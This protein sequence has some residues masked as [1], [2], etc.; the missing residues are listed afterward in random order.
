[1]KR[2]LGLL[3]VLP[4]VLAV[5]ACAPARLP[6]V[7]LKTHSASAAASATPSA[8]P[9][10]QSPVSPPTINST[11][12]LINGVPDPT[13]DTT[14]SAFGEWAFFTDAQKQVWCQFTIFSA[15]AP[16][17]YCFVVGSGKSA[18]T[19]T[20]P[21]GVT[22]GCDMSSSLAIDGYGLGLAVEGLPNG[23]ESGWAGC[24]NDFFAP[25]A[26]LAKTKVLPSGGT[27]A[28]SPFSCT[29]TASVAT[30]HYT[31]SYSGGSGTITLGLHVATFSQT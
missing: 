1:M 19:F 15:D 13:T 27:L 24:S 12:Y 31:D 25:A 7:S 5:A 28:V 8:T 4:L 21:A 10:A 22:N 29:V 17:S 14:G 3:L 18:K 11:D 9:T 6:H 30:C 23:T 20:V 16:A 26:D 2:S